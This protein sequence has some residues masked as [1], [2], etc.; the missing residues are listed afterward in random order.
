MSRYY[1]RIGIACTYIGLVVGELHAC[2][3]MSPVPI[4][5][6]HNTTVYVPVGE[7]YPFYD[8]G[9]YDPDDDPPG[10]TGSQA[11]QDA[12][13]SWRWWVDYWYLWDSY[14]YTYFWSNYPGWYYLALEVEDDDYEW[15]EYCD[16]VDICV[17]AAI[18]DFIQA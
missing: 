10:Q 6:P 12:I 15:S 9:S 13:I 11:A 2:T 17:F 18:L 7:D 5:S 8:N 14:P 16:Y 1:L 4:M 3:K